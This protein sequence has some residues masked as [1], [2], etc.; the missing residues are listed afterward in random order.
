MHERILEI[1]L[2][3]AGPKQ[4]PEFHVASMQKYLAYES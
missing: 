1:H 4:N 3:P 2:A